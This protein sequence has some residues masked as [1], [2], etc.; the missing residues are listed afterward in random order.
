MNR[1]HCNVTSSTRPSSTFPFNFRISFATSL[2]QLIRFHFPIRYK[3]L[4]ILY[5]RFSFSP[6]R[7]KLRTIF[8]SFSAFSFRSITLLIVPSAFR[9]GTSYDRDL[10]DQARHILLPV[11]HLPCP[12]AAFLPIKGLSLISFIDFTRF[13]CRSARVSWPY[14]NLTLIIFIKYYPEKISF[15][16]QFSLNCSF[17]CG[18]K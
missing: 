4:A 18:E 8:S 1:L 12:A 9:N 14:Y 15:S 11:K 7:I 10:T 17:P 6:F 16:A 13:P 3:S 5:N 2:A